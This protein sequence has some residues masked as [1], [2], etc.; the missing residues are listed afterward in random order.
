[1]SKATDIVDG[2]GSQFLTYTDSG[3]LLSETNSSVILAGIQIANRYDSLLRRT[4]L[5]ALV[6][7]YQY[8]SYSYLYDAASRL[9]NVSDGTYNASYSFLANS[10]LLSQIT[11]RSN[12]T[13][14]M[15]TANQYHFLNRVLPI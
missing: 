12:T 4:N 14:R 9:T 2:S 13:V 5:Q 15:T 11:C 1:Q 7:N 6:T 3:L 10:P 8:L